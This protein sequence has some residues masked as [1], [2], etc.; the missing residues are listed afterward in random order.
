MIGAIVLAAG[1]S[2]RM[3]TN[4]LV[5][6]FRGRPLIRHAV[7]AVVAS[8]AA[9]VVVVT[10]SGGAEVSAVLK[11]L[12]IEIVENRDFSMGLSESLKCGVRSLP[13]SCEGAVVML[14][15]MPLV[16]AD[17]VDSLIA[18]FDAA[19]SICIPVRGGRRGNP[20]LWG[21]QHFPAILALEG[22]RGA[23][24]LL[25]SRAVCEV[26]APDDGIFIDIDTTADLE[27]YGP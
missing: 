25:P 3:L 21:R 23:K 4:K 1:L 7:D 19:H 14:G 13:A 15:D 11:G 20:V 16:T 8:R 18:H 12:D 22:D 9:P 26:P 10:G 6:P 17:L 27:T 2:S 24:S 5:M